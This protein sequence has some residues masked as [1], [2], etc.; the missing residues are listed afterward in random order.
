MLHLL[1]IE[2]SNL[3]RERTPMKQKEAIDG[4]SIILARNHKISIVDMEALKHSFHQNDDIQFEDFLLEEGI[5]EKEDLLE[6]LSQYYKVPQ[7]DVV[8]LF[9]EHYLMSLFPK[10]VLIEHMMLPISREDDTLWVV[11]AEP[12][13]PHLPVVLGRY[14]SHNIAFMVGIPQDIIDTIREFADQSDTY[15]P[16]DIQNQQ[17]ERSQQEVHTPYDEDP[18]IPLIVEETIDDYESK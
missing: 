8:G 18:R 7:C 11:A 3:L 2:Y 9:V 4:L 12:N 15:Q 10:D 5:V 17:M 14:V 1:H 6:A 13:D 16:N